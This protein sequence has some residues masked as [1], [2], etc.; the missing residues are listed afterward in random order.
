VVLVESR[1]VAA[2]ERTT[3]RHC[4]NSMSLAVGTEAVMSFSLW[5]S[6]TA[7]SGYIQMNYSKVKKS[8]QASSPGNLDTTISPKTLT[9]CE[10][11]E[12][13]C[14]SKSRA[15]SS[16]SGTILARHI[17]ILSVSRWLG[18]KGGSFHG[19]TH[20]RSLSHDT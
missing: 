6:R 11:N 18:T 20:A 9:V 10:N 7:L 12:N 3:T 19:R 4:M 17:H 15:V 2:V 5:A 8:S 16:V 1:Q 14:N 13:S